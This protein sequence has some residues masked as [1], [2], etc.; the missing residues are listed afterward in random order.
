[1]LFIYLFTSW[2]LGDRMCTAQLV[3]NS[4]AQWTVLPPSLESWGLQ[5]HM[6]LYPSM[7]C[8]D[9]CEI[10]VWL[11]F[12]SLLSWEVIE[13]LGNAVR[14]LPKLHAN[15]CSKTQ[16][17]FCLYLVFAKG[18]GVRPGLSYHE[19]MF[20]HNRHIHYKLPET[21]VCWLLQSA[22][23]FSNSLFYSLR[24][25]QSTIPLCRLACWWY[26]PTGGAAEQARALFHW[27]LLSLEAAGRPD[28]GRSF[29]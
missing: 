2:C 10:L 7:I 8:Y 9:A 15:R 4:W 21:A 6:A 19:H 17:L 23:F 1:M 22:L 20:F 12:L 25:K 27:L 26:L 28:S 24:L 5:R 14:Y 18:R 3:P 29:L 16:S 11:P 13:L